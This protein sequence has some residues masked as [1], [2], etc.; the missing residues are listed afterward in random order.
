MEFQN[1]NIVGRSMDFLLQLFA[2]HCGMT[3]QE[4][5]GGLFAQLYSRAA[6]NLPIVPETAYALGHP[7]YVFA[8][9]PENS[10]QL[11]WDILQAIGHLAGGYN[12]MSYIKRS[13]R[14]NRMFMMKIQSAVSLSDY[15][16]IVPLYQ[17]RIEE[18]ATGKGL[19]LFLY[20]ADSGVARTKH[21]ASYHDTE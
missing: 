6:H 8:L 7:G 10:P 15:F 1:T 12:H 4:Y 13:S 2:Q 9:I 18:N 14:Q 17:S 5:C 21:T 19:H 3:V 20:D 16:D 11:Y